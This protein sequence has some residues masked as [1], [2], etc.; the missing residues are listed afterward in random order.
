MD[1]NDYT[2]TVV[3]TYIF[4]EPGLV[5]LIL[6]YIPLDELLLTG[7]YEHSKKW[8]LNHCV[9]KP[10][11]VLTEDEENI[12]ITRIVLTQGNAK[13]DARYIIQFSPRLRYV[14]MKYARSFK[15][16]LCK[17]IIQQEYLTHGV[18][19]IRDLVRDL[20]HTLT[21]DYASGILHAS[22]TYHDET[23]LQLLLNRCD[24]EKMNI[25]I[26]EVI[27]RGR[28]D[29]AVMMYNVY[30]ISP[31]ILRECIG[32]L[33]CFHMDTL[34]NRLLH[35]YIPPP[36]PYID[37]YCDPLQSAALYHPNLIPKLVQLKLFRQ[38]QDILFYT[39]VDNATYAEY[40][41]QLNYTQANFDYALRYLEKQGDTRS[42]ILRSCANLRD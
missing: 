12:V 26:Q 16:S 8:F 37:A 27:G 38:D 4:A 11:R 32:K 34:L 5:R 22:L 25:L 10:N 19:L 35:D 39:Q 21:Q 20:T 29:V 40:V 42:N 18:T 1:V 24:D 13:I 6:T 2:V 3:L 31:Q 33:F 14:I 23:T 15:H 28:E 36:H 7:V 9:I 41:S 17:F 30:K